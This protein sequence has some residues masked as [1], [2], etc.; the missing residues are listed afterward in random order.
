MIIEIISLIF[1]S[2][3]NFCNV[4]SKAIQPKFVFHLSCFPSIFNPLNSFSSSFILCW[5]FCCCLIRQKILKSKL[6][7]N[8][9]F[10]IFILKIY[11]FEF[12]WILFCRR[13]VFF[14]LLS[15]PFQ[16]FVCESGR[17]CLAPH[18]YCQFHQPIFV[19]WLITKLVC[20]KNEKMY[21]TI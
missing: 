18:M 5:S 1:L 20:F 13:I 15:W 9:V 3:A 16:R 7:F 10:I 8:T 11:I 2:T 14:F 17:V 12:Y 4:M 6:K 21:K 19:Q